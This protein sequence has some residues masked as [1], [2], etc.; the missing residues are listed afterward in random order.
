MPSWI[1]WVL[2]ALG[3]VLTGL[4]ILSPFLTW[5]SK[6]MIKKVIRHKFENERE[7]LKYQIA[8]LRDEVRV[9]IADRLWDVD[10]K[11]AG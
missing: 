2:N 5:L 1:E 3:L 6:L 4:T 9:M 8:T 7:A 10:L 11:K